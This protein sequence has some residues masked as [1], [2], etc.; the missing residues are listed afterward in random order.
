M[1]E[2]CH[3]GFALMSDQAAA[4]AGE[5]EWLTLYRAH[6]EPEA[7]AGAWYHGLEGDALEEAKRD[8]PTARARL[9]RL[10]VDSEC[11][12]VRADAANGWKYT[13]A[14]LRAA[15]AAAGIPPPKS[16]RPQDGA[17]AASGSGAA[18][19]SRLVAEGDGKPGSLAVW[20]SDFGAASNTAQLREKG[21]THRLN[22][23]TEACGRLPKDD[24][25]QTVDIPMED[26]FDEERG[27][28]MIDVWAQQLREAVT[29]LRAW[30]IQGAIV[31][32]NCQ[33]GKNRSGAVCLAWLCTECGWKMEAAAEHLRSVTALALGNPHLVRAC[34]IFLGSDASVPLNPAHDGGGWVCIS[35]PG[36]PR[37]GAAEEG[38]DLAL[39]ALQK[40]RAEG[41][42]GTAL[43][44]GAAAEESEAESSD[45]GPDVVPIFDNELS[46]VD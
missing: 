9:R 42:F 24:G 8:A 34:G 38:E 11:P 46:D 37:G 43:A 26:V 19:A 17:P 30:R 28:E 13:G 39:K 3:R 1:S 44:P 36:T 2:F 40:L 41:G 6:A 21:V 29:L 18:N 4:S 23:A 14:I 16:R 25:I 10:I 35:P 27:Q 32:V 31:N 5:P 7:V 15:D 22:V 20:W 12:E 45:P 33:M